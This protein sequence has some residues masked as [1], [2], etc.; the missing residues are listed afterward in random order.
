MPLEN[1]VARISPEK[2]IGNPAGIFVSSVTYDHRR[3]SPG[4][5]H[6]CLPGKRVDG[7]DFAAQAAQAGAVAFICERFLKDEAKNV[8]QL[9]VGPGRARPA[10]ALGACVLWGD[11]ASSLKTVGVTGTN[12]KT[13][14]TYFLRSVLDANGWPTAVIG[15]LGG[16]RTT[17]EAPDL[18]QA[19][20]HARDTERRA[21]ALEV[22]SH[23]LAQHRLDGYRHNVAVFTNLSQDHLDYHGTMEA[24][25]AAKELLFRPEHAM[26]A[27][28]NG[29][30]EFGRRLLS[31]AAIPMG[32]FS[33]DQAEELEVGLLESRFRLEGEPVRLRPGGEINVKNALA[34]AAAARVLGVPAATIAAGLSA[35]EGPAGRLEAVPN[36]LGAR[37]VVDYAHTPAGLREILQVARAEA[38][39]NGGRVIV[40]FGCGG[41]RDRDK[42]PMMGSI[43][44]HYSDIAVLTSDNPRK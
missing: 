5:L 22:S 12:G 29:D 8:V 26:E 23:A 38:A 13:T 11:P 39:G 3:V 2:V 4:A 36:S 24:Y 25:F 32:T 10:M 44:T 35:A 16:P 20:A 9:L 41:D 15:T 33:L 30:D 27:V 18:Q 28:V 6:C 31:T 17:P 1:F 19:L 34:A 42:R 37:V 7:H 43:A 14:T 40:V 21:V